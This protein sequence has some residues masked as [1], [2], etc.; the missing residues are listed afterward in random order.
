MALVYIP[1][2]LSKIPLTAPNARGKENPNGYLTGYP[3]GHT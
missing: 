3:Q 2:P 1:L